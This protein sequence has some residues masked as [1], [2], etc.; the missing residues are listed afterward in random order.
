[1]GPLKTSH[2][3][4]IEALSIQ[5]G[6]TSH[7]GTGSGTQEG[8]GGTLPD[9]GLLLQPDRCAQGRPG[10]FLGWSHSLLGSSGQQGRGGWSGLLETKVVLIFHPLSLPRGPPSAL[11][12]TSALLATVQVP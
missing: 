5:P 3:S 12:G 2:L 10:A 6:L 8:K 1:M 9:S 7:L 4:S 11:L